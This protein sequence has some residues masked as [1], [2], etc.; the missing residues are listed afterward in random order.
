MTQALMMKHQEHA[1][2]QSSLCTKERT[3]RNVHSVH[4]YGPAHRSGLVPL[5]HVLKPLTCGDKVISSFL[6]H[7]RERCSVW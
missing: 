1:V 3:P 4:C 6:N 2:Q 5:F 7:E